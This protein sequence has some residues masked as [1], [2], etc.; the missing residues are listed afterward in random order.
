MCEAAMI[1]TQKTI[2]SMVNQTLITH[3]APQK[4]HTHDW[5][6]WVFNIIA[7]CACARCAGCGIFL[8]IIS[9]IRSL[10]GLIG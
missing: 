3:T 8:G 6:Q 9:K 2:L 10:T 5:G 4:V 7:E 1:M